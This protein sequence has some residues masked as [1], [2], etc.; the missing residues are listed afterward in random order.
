M[1]NNASDEMSKELLKE[2]SKELVSSILQIHNKKRD[3]FWYRFRDHDEDVPERLPKIR[4]NSIGDEQNEYN[5]MKEV[6][7]KL[8]RLSLRKQLGVDQ[9]LFQK[10]LVKE[11]V[12]AKYGKGHRFSELKAKDFL[13]NYGFPDAEI[14]VAKSVLNKKRSYL[15]LGNK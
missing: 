1:V 2:L 8:D 11:Q 13:N 5:E 12:L 9:D 15:R 7:V 3:S 4:A 14:E 6:V 10:V